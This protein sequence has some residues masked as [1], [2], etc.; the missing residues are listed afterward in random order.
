LAHHVR[1]GATLG[2]DGKTRDAFFLDHARDWNFAVNAR[3]CNAAACLLSSRK[4]L[5]SFAPRIAALLRRSLLL[6]T[7]EPLTGERMSGSSRGRWEM[8]V[9][10]KDV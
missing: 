5:L 9:S 8:G 1:A 7:S 4:S 3:D 10:L 2:H 6:A